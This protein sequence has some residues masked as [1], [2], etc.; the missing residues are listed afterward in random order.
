MLNY[1]TISQRQLSNNTRIIPRLDVLNNEFISSFVPINNSIIH[2]AKTDICYSQIIEGNSSIVHGRAGN[3]KSGCIIELLEK[4]KDKNVVHLALKLDRRHPE[5]TSEKFGQNM[6]LPASPILCLDAIS[7][8]DEAVLILDQLDAIRWT[9]VHSKTALEVCKEMIREAHY[10]NKNRDKKI[11]IVLVCRT[12]DFENDI[13]VKSLIT[14]NVEKDEQ[15]SWKSISIDE[16]EEVEVKAV[17]GNEYDFFS[18]KMKEI[19]RNPNNL[20][21][22]TNLDEKRRNGIFISSSELIKQWWNQ[23]CYECEKIELTSYDI[24]RVRDTIVQ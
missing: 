8:T 14:S 19:I 11:V 10:I 21:I 6:G 18:K 15:L 20:F 3:G 5:H 4:L 23:I 13:G 9:S 24:F 22:W 12:F 1:P 16:L 2:R 7:K 17:V